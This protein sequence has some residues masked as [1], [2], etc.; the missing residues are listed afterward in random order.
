[1]IAYFVE[2]LEEYNNPYHEIPDFDL[3]IL[4]HV[5]HVQFHG[6]YSRIRD[7]ILN[8]EDETGIDSLTIIARSED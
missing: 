5:T 2:N 3:N 8:L 7:V 6:N 4:N 1:M